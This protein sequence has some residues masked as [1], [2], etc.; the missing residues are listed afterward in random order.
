MQ[1]SRRLGRWVEG[2]GTLTKTCNVKC[3]HQTQNLLRFDSTLHTEKNMHRCWQHTW[4]IMSM[5]G[6]LVKQTLPVAR[7]ASGTWVNFKDYAVKSWFRRCG[8]EDLIIYALAVPT[9]PHPVWWPMRCNLILSVPVIRTGKDNEVGNVEIDGMM[10][11][12]TW[13]WC[14]AGTMP[15]KHLSRSDSV[16]RERL[17]E[18]S[19]SDAEL[20]SS[21][22]PL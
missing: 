4:D 22:L 19:G 21:L 10:E 12:T 5:T 2:F 6:W 1:P 3:L 17:S 11:A 18:F 13:L 9:G 7:S 20:F 8:T 14:G 15:L 16:W